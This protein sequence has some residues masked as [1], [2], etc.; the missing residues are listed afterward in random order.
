MRPK[1]EALTILQLEALGEALLDFREIADRDTWLRKHQYRQ[2]YSIIA[3]PNNV[4]FKLG[5]KASMA[6]DIN[7]RAEHELPLLP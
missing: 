6:L 4:R 3:G 1:I 5:V 2:P 7:L